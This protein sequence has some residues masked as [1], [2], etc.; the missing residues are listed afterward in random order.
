MWFFKFS[1]CTRKLR[2]LERE[3]INNHLANIGIK[4]VSKAIKNARHFFVVFIDERNKT[5][6]LKLRSQLERR[7]NNMI[8]S[9]M[10]FYD[11]MELLIGVS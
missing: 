3:P 9:E 5:E 7:L 8:L 6:L 2:I 1:T 10:K 11:D 4:G